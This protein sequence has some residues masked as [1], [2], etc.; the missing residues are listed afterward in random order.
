LAS[1]DRGLTAEQVRDILAG[2]LAQSGEKNLKIGA[3]TPKADG[4]VTIEITTANGS[5]VSARDYSTK[6]GLPA[7]AT[8][9]C[10]RVEQAVTERREAREQTRGERREGRRFLRGRGGPG[11]DEG[12]GARMGGGF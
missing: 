8:A 10:A 9:R 11:R 6:T 4:I 12:F 5:L 1:M 2:R 7:E 3:V